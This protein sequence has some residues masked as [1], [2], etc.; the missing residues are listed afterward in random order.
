M[1]STAV[2]AGNRRT[3]TWPV[4]LADESA[5]LSTADITVLRTDATGTVEVDDVVI[6]DEAQTVAATVT[7][8][9]DFTGPV[10]IR[11]DIDDADGDLAAEQY[12][13]YVTAASGQRPD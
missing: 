2:L 3:I 12:R 8:A 1:S 13:F 10:D 5:S 4:T 6:D 9:D 7:F 11:L